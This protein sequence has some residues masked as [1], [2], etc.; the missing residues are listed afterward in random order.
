MLK[1]ELPSDIK[2]LPKFKSL[3]KTFLSISDISASNA[4]DLIMTAS[5]AIYNTMAH[6]SGEVILF[7]VE[8]SDR[9]IKASVKQEMAYIYII[10]TVIK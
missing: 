7:S 10:F 2:Q 6:L 9:E 4:S 8:I 1:I 5:V 3:L